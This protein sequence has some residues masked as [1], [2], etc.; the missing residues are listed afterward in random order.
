MTIY[1][2][3]IHENDTFNNNKSFEHRGENI[4]TRYLARCA[5]IVSIV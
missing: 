1:N 2:F 4:N 5:N 3:I